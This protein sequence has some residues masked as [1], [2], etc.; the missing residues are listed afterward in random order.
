MEYRDEDFNGRDVLLDGNTLTGCT[1]SNCRVF[2]SGIMPGT[3]IANNFYE[4]IDW[5]FIGPA[6]LT[7]QF[8][9]LLYLKTGEGGR[10]LIEQLFDDIRTGRVLGLESPEP[11]EPD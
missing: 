2:F 9:S 7:L 11:P 4:G 8:M 5:R 1:F 6:G 3:L 10:T